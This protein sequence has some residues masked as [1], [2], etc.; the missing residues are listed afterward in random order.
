MPRQASQITALFTPPQTKKHPRD[1]SDGRQ[2]KIYKRVC[3][4]AVINAFEK[5]THLIGK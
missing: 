4:A 3:C 1:A 5:G 2:V